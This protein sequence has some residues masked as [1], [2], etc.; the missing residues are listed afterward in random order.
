MSDPVGSAPLGELLE[1][2][3]DHRGKTP[4]KLGGDFVSEGVPVISAINIKD[5]HIV[6]GSPQRYVTR[7]MFER[8]MPA[9]I[10]ASDVLL[11]SEA[12]LGEVARVRTSDPIVLGQR[13]FG[14]RGRPAVL[15]DGYLYYALQWRP[16]R[17]QLVARATGTTVSGISQAE[18]VRVTLPVPPLP[19]Q[20]E[21]A[22]VLGA[23]DDL[24]D[25]R[26]TTIR[27]ALDLARTVGVATCSEADGPIVR[28]GD[29]A[30]VTKG[31]SYRS[32]DLREGGGWLVSLKC[33]GR[34]GDFNFDGL[35]PYVG[36]SKPSQ[37]VVP[38]DVLVAQTDLT[39]RAEVI[40]RAVRVPNT[41]LGG[42]LVA[43]LDFAVVRPRQAL[44]RES[45]LALLSTQAFRDHALGYCNGTTVLHL[46]SLALPSYE[47]TLP[48]PRMISHITSTTRPLFDLADSSAREIRTIESLRNALLPRLMSGEVPV[49]IRTVAEAV[50]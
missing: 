21:I 48:N 17:E 25:G 33:V 10:Q 44:T 30:D 16:I 12:P 32:A 23:L 6:P 36:P 35:K 13:L 9:K 38:S 29:A 47:F 49:P 34:S 45:L 20:S 43:S 19:A 27:A 28:L 2:V 11:T 37:L 3:I 42:G 26:K 22:E 4:K 24:I 18:L 8:W 5:G 46:G 50:S 14:L 41:G 40:G 7:E 39:Q 31:V 15:D 1:L